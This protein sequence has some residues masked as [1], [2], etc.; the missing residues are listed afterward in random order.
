MK[1]DA[2]DDKHYH[3]ALNLSGMR[4]WRPIKSYIYNRHKILVNFATNI[5]GYIAVYRYVCKGKP[6]TDVFH[7]LGHSD[8]SNISSPVT[9][10][11]MKKFQ[12]N[13]KKRRFSATNTEKNTPPKN[14]EKLYKEKKTDKLS[15]FRFYEQNHHQKRA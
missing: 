2:D 14:P 10:N 1:D 12:S 6:L 8:M 11:A 9:K 15:R 4:R 13:A 5:C 3:I 7:S